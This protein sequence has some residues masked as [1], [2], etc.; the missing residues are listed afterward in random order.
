V[1][2][3]AI[4]AAVGVAFV[5]MTDEQRAKLEAFRTRVGRSPEEGKPVKLNP[6]HM[7]G[8]P[9]SMRGIPMLVNGGV[10]GVITGTRPGDSAEILEA[11]NRHIAKYRGRR[12]PRA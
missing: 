3:P 9:A 7:P 12:R 2:D 6:R 5:Q 11:D 8:D 1:F 4:I 10:G